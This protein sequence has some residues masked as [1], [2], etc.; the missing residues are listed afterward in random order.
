L[1]IGV[2]VISEGILPVVCLRIR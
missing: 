1:I 2:I